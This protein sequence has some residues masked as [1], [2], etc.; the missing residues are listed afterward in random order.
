MLYLWS[1]VCAT[2]EARARTMYLPLTVYRVSFACS[3]ILFHCDISTFVKVLHLVLCKSLKPHHITSAREVVS[4][5][6]CAWYSVILSVNRITQNFLMNSDTKIKI[7]KKKKKTLWG[8]SVGS[9][10]QSVWFHPTST[11]VFKVSVMICWSKIDKKPYNLE[12]MT[13]KSVLCIVIM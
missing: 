11:E 4:V 3:T 6:I 9:S 7:F 8:C 12:S 13:L 10:D 5:C 2:P 1:A